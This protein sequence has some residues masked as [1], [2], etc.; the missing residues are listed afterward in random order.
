MPTYLYRIQ[1]TRGAMLAE[2]PTPEEARAIGAHF[3]YLQALA[4]AGRLFMAGRTLNTDAS[5]FGI[6]L[7][8]ARDDDAAQAVLRDDP[9]VR[10]G[11]MRGEVLPFRAA[12]WAGDPRPAGTPGAT[13]AAGAAPQCAQ[14]LR[15]QL[16][17][18]PDAP[19]Y[20]TLML[21]AYGQAADA[22]TSTAEERAREPLAWWE[23]RIAAPDGGSTCF[24]A[25]DG[26]HLVGTVALE[27]ASKPK[28]RHAALVLG[29]Y[30]QA[31]ARRQGG[32]R[33]LMQAAL[34]AAR[35]R[36]GL[37]QL[38]LTVTEGNRPAIALYESLGFRRW[39]L[40]PEA[41]LTPS[42]YKGKVHMALTLP[43]AAP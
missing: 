13:P 33:L 27:Y 4:E 25:F 17:A 16:L 15:V 29:M 2:G 11:V 20:R 32:G 42:G 7:Y 9:A 18:P 34:A 28:T 38:R 8:E 36:P 31:R 40:E 5:S 12:L 21:E 26:E 6:A 3:A 39:G 22:F 1:P 10:E 41:I 14:A 23:G 35:A 37:R 30:V 43:G 19:A 24:G